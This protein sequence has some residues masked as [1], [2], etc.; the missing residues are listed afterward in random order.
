[1]RPCSLVGL[2]S[3][4]DAQCIKSITAEYKMYWQ[5]LLE[6]LFNGY[7]MPPTPCPILYMGPI[8]ALM[9]PYGPLWAHMGPSWC[10][11]LG[12]PF[13]STSFLTLKNHI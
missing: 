4:L 3:S 5:E 10:E 6:D 2:M 1:M 11:R 9:R 13:A 7:A 8:W 12:Q